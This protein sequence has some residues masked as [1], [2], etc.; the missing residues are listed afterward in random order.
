VGWQE[1]LG[2]IVSVVVG[3]NK[4]CL[5]YKVV[6]KY[7]RI[8]VRTSNYSEA[9][10]LTEIQA[11]KLRIKNEVNF[12]YKKKR[13]LN[14]QLYTSHIHNANIWGNM[15]NIIS[16]NI[17]NTLD[18]AMKLKYNHIN[19]KLNKLKEDN[20]IQ[21][22]TTQNEHRFYQRVENLSDITFNQEEITLLGKGLKYNLHLK[23]K[24][25][26]RTLAIEAEAAI[27][28]LSLREQAFMRQSVANNL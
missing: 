13:Q 25:W 27:N 5:M 23:Q 28:L 20:T 21:H 1:S 6:P 9:A 22:N 19:N 18:N 26:I 4:S 14:I 11:S 3:F 24:N 10:K 2:M 16:E 8:N 12:L 17:N 7:A 15:W